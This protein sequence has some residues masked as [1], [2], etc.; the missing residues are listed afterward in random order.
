[1][2]MT[3]TL[4]HQNLGNIL[5]TGRSIG[6]IARSRSFPKQEILDRP[7]I[8]SPPAT[9]LGGDFLTESQSTRSSTVSPSAAG[10]SVATLCLCAGLV[11]LPYV[12]HHDASFV[13]SAHACA[14]HIP[15]TPLTRTPFPR[16]L[17]SSFNYEYASSTA[18]FSSRLSR[19][20]I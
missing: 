5:Y 3:A 8:W 17:P 12:F 19:R 6:Q 11:R 13:F 18:S 1:V 20:G 7:P 4:D 2:L 16:L 15:S 14:R 9:E 10:V